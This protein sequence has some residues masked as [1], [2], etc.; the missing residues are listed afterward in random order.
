MKWQGT[1][2]KIDPVI[3]ELLAGVG[4]RS[5]FRSQGLRRVAIISIGNFADQA[6]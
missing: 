1:A 2:S 3:D 6:R 5:A 4:F